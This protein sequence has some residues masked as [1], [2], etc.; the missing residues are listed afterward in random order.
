MKITKRFFQ[1]V[2]IAGILVVFW[3][4]SG[5]MQE[6]DTM[7]SLK[8]T[9]TEFVRLWSQVDRLV[10]EQKFREAENN[11]ALILEKAMTDNNDAEWT[12]AL[13]RII[14]FKQTLHGYEESIRFLLETPWPDDPVSHALLSLV[15]ATAIQNYYQAYRWEI[16]QREM[17]IS[18]DDLD[19]RQWTT[20]QIYDRARSWYA[21]AWK[22]RDGLGKIPVTA[23]PELIL[24]RNYPDNIRVSLRDFISYQW[25]DL[26]SDSSTWPARESAIVYTLPFDDWVSPG[27]PVT[28]AA[29]DADQHPLAQAMQ[30]LSDLE[31]WHQ[32]NNDRQNVLETRMERLRILR[33]HFTNT[34]RKD[35]IETEYR[36]LINAYIDVPWSASAIWELADMKRQSNR[37]VKAWETAKKGWDTHPD[38]MGGKLCRALMSQLEAP[39]YTIES[40]AID[41][42][43]KRSIR[44]THANM[45]TLYF[46][47]YRLDF[48]SILS[49]NMTHGYLT[50]FNLTH[51]QQ[52]E[53]VHETRPV[54]TWEV[55]LEDPGDYADHETYTI[56][57][58]TQHGL[59]LIAASH[60]QAFTSRNNRIDAVMFNAGSL[61]MTGSN[62]NDQF[63]IQVF[64]GQSGHPV[65][66]ADITMYPRVWRAEQFR[67]IKRR[68][69]SDGRASSGESGTHS[70][71]VIARKDDSLIYQHF[72]IGGRGESRHQIRDYIYTD[73]SIYRPGQQV[74]VKVLSFEGRDSNYRVRPGRPVS[75]SFHDPNRELIETVHLTTNDYGSASATFTIP[76]GR[77]LGVYRLKSSSGNATVRVEE[78]K[79]PTFEVA[80]EPPE[81]EVVLNR[82]VKITGRADYY[83]GMP[84]SEGTV[85]WRV[86]RRPRWPTWWFWWRPSP[87]SQQAFELAAGE[88]SLNLDGTFT[89]SFLP[90]SDPDTDDRSVTWAFEITAVVTDSGG[91]TRTGQMTLNLGH[92]AVTA[93]ISIPGS[94]FSPNQPAEMTV[95]RST[96]DGKPRSGKGNYHI[97]RLEQP[98]DILS[99]SKLPVHEKMLPD[100]ALP[101]DTMHP[102]WTNEPGY[103]NRIR[104]WADG[105]R[106]ARGTLGH[107][108]NGKATVS[109]N[110][111]TGAYRIYYTTQDEYDVEYKTHSE[112][113]VLDEGTALNVPVYMLLNS[114]LTHVGNTL[115]V[116][117]GTGYTGQEYWFEMSQNNTVIRRER[118]T[119]NGKARKITI[120]IDES[121]RGGFGLSLYLVNDYSLISETAFIPVPWTNK[122]LKLEFS[123]FRDL[124]RPGQDETWKVTVRGPD[125]EKVAAELLAY[126]YDRSLDFFVSHTFPRV[127]SLYPTHSMRYLNQWSTRL[128]ANRLLNHNWF[129]TI[130]AASYETDRIIYHSGYG[131]GGPGQRGHGG[132]MRMQQF[133]AMHDEMDGMVYSMS[134][135]TDMAEPAPMMEKAAEPP[136]PREPE[137]P[138]IDSDIPDVPDIEFREDFNE[139]AFFLPHLISDS[140]SVATI[141]FTVP[142]SVTSWN[143]FVHAVT[144]DMKSA[145]L[146]KEVQTRKELMVRPYMPRFFRE[147]DKGDL[148]VVVNNAGDEPLAG[149]VYLQI[150][151][152]DTDEDRTADFSPSARTL[153]FNAKAGESDTVTF[154]VSAP[155]RIGFY[156]FKVSAV[157]D[158]ISDG[159][160]RP[161]PVLPGRIHLAQSRFVTL[162]DDD[163]RTMVL[164][165]LLDSETD[166][167]LIH[168]SLVVT[169]EGQLFYHVLKALP[170]LVNY[171]FECTEQTLNRFL[172]TGIVTSLYD[173]YPAVAKAA[174]AFSERETI[175]E[176]WDQNDPNRR[177]ALT[178]TPWLQTARGGISGD[179]LLNVLKPVVAKSQRDDS[180]VKLQNAQNPSGAFP[181]F[182]G[183]PDSPYITL[184]MLYGFAKAQEFNI[185]VPRTMVENACR[186]L[187]NH[188]RSYYKPKFKVRDYS[189]EFLVFLNYVLSCF[190]DES[191]YKSGFSAAERQEMLDHTFRNWKSVSPYCK[192][193]LALTLHRENRPGDA[194]L[195]MDSIMDS[196]ITR[197][198]QGTFWAPEDR[199]WLWYNDTIE[200]HAMMLRALMELNPDDDRTDGLALWLFLN[201]KMNHWKSTRTTAEVIYSL[202][203]YLTAS[204]AMGVR[205][206]AKVTV[207]PLAET[208]VFDPEVFEAGR[209]RIEIPGED[210]EP[211]M[212]EVTV[213]KQGKGFMFASMNWQYSTEKMPD[214]ARG[215]FLAVTRQYFLRKSE[216]GEIVLKPLLDGVPIAVGDQVEVHL[217]IT[218]KHPMEY[219]HLMDPRGAG[220]EP[221]SHLSGYRWDLGISRYEETRDSCANFFFEWL[222]QGEYTFKY[223]IRASMAGTFKVGPATLQ[224]MYAPEFA[225]FSAGHVLTIQ[226]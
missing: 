222:P 221:E 126:M 70:M 86:V 183:G 225:A 108:E 189:S 109:H 54:Y 78:Y 155:E 212:G 102:R 81:T 31:A 226:P 209:C 132:V 160:R 69:D 66:D 195:V 151:D 23:F 56:P 169:I 125:S 113:L 68:T 191:W 206:T 180:I 175:W 101:G 200:S 194:K 186:F 5:T 174:E 147:G 217:S 3:S 74:H 137:S 7:Q 21:D 123:T 143:V 156:A 72:N 124:L 84:V 91:E 120:D 179:D 148:R 153:P 110:L 11:T 107:D 215:D 106:V 19:I 190:P 34:R 213:D 207:G 40:M 130:G 176:Q 75:V 121:M 57:P 178:E 32:S 196:A 122:E 67:T 45:E 15:A 73:R 184:Y 163:T 164:Q 166:P 14:F 214:E 201:K 99:A 33:R 62:S 131:I 118:F 145:V 29:I 1:C 63:E 112:F 24:R 100:N 117:V 116:I 93:S 146:Q 55:S 197:L 168:E 114:Y 42:L 158:D 83:F 88:T 133:G 87:P 211:V 220:F 96:L 28:S 142:D 104:Q 170:Y 204:D 49:Q 216:G 80:V 82:Q 141:A 95:I 134:P 79:R 92:C 98:E 50:G 8:S 13:A 192:A 136:S 205:E 60:N 135:E 18:E 22:Q 157:A 139:T 208:C 144:K 44:I 187:G 115:E 46:R 103:R 199:G 51:D 90:E 224:S 119:G 30:I 154:N 193:M 198:D 202:A 165:D 37:L 188:F 71:F 47:A 4:G 203:H 219:V 181:W 2:G 152:P 64:D 52:A 89:L 6:T 159:E 218:A 129:Q 58:I 171:P 26:M 138:P 10:S 150:V 149:T 223:R 36:R 97:V 127:S 9:D 76:D 111:E 77:V 185:D 41:T 161:I 172:S 61:V 27:R 210:I 16:T 25:S 65:H 12:K 94:F 162:K 85:A 38:S 17:V 140:D 182:P 173:Q 48:D 128:T 177:M 35:A 167:T 43:N 20:A 53:I 59:Y 105:P 39:R